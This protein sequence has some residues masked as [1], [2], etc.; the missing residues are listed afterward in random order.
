MSHDVE[1]FNLKVD[2]NPHE[3]GTTT[4]SGDGIILTVTPAKTFP[5]VIPGTS[6]TV[7]FEFNPQ[8]G[9]AEEHPLKKSSAS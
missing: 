4:M 2:E 1:L 7:T 3:D 9:R 6:V 5:T 8:L